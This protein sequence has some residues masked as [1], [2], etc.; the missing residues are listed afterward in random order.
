MSDSTVSPAIRSA[1]STASRIACS[2][3]SRSTTAPALMP[4]ERWKPKPSTS[5][6]WVRPGSTS[7]PWRGVSR[8]M[9]QQILEVPTSRIDTTAGRRDGKARIRWTR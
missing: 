9:M 2:A 6:E 7:P 3:W 5:I 1:E 8:A 4:R